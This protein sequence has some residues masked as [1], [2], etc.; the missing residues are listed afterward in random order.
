MI[1]KTLLGVLI[2]IFLVA[3]NASAQT[4]FSNNTGITITDTTSGAIV[5]QTATP[6]P[7]TIAVSGLGTSV[8]KVTVTLTNF[9]HTFQ[10]DAGFLLVSPTGQKVRLITDCGGN[11]AGAV[12]L[13]FDDAAAGSVTCNATLVSGT[14]KP[15][16]GGVSITGGAA[17]PANFPAPAPTSPYSLLLSSFNGTNPN[18]TWSLYVDDDST[19]GAGSITGWSLTITA[20]QPTAAPAIIEGRITTSAGRGIS[21]ASV[22]LLNT[23][24]QENKITLT[25]PFGYFRFADLPTGA[26][27]I[28]T[29]KDK[30][31]TFFN[32]TQAIQVFGNMEVNFVGE[33]SSKLINK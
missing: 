9:I 21:K 18:G 24:T 26:F 27:Y 19:G 5:P 11:N 7:S 28:V 25:N 16:Q 17:H 15:T 8:T 30:R 1:Q 3:F 29:V 33:S 31:Y 13:T 14:Y 22:S 2:I 32:E 6:Y 12:T 23:S 10:D 20:G 4:T